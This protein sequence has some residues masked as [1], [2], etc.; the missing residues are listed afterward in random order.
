MIKNNNVIYCSNEIKS[1][2]LTEIRIR[3]PLEYAQYKIERFNKYRYNN[4]PPVREN[5]F[6]IQRDFPKNIELFFQILE[7]AKKQNAP[8][9]YEL[10]DLLFELPE[11][12]PLM[13]TGCYSINLIPILNAVCEADLVTVSTNPI[14]DYL[15]PFNPNIKV[16]PNYLIDKY[17]EFL[18]IRNQQ[19]NPDRIVIGYIGGATHLEDMEMVIEPLLKINDQYSEKIQFIFFGLNPPEIFKKRTTVRVKSIV[20]VYKNYAKALKNQNFDILIAPLI[21][22]EFNQAKSNIKYLEYSTLGAPGIYS[23]VKPFSEIVK[24]GKNGLLASSHQEWFDCL[25]A[26]IE[27][28]E[29]RREIA[30]NAQKTVKSNYMLSQHANEWSVAYQSIEIT[31]NKWSIKFSSKN[32]DQ[33][34]KILKHIYNLQQKQCQQL[35][36]Q[37]NPNKSIMQFCIQK[38]NSSISK[39]TKIFISIFSNFFKK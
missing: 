33:K 12:H 20:P 11:N 10:D 1:S 13:K 23:N 27:S 35:I 17:W 26:L 14:A 9:I 16:L 8:L 37:K 18:P 36:D 38:L 21:N 29:M 30:L 7:E 31:S 4:I 15:R 28:P 22:N 25:K 6:I 24:N 5:L 32:V 2:A 34:N 3:A 39:L 19:N